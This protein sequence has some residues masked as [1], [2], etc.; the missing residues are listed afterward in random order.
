M[1]KSKNKETFNKFMIVS[2]MKYLRKIM[3]YILDNFDKDKFEL[4][5]FFKQD[6]E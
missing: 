1:K 5:I 4:E 2:D 3:N 6:K